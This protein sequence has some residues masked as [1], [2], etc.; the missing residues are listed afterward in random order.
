MKRKFNPDRLTP[1]ELELM[2]ILWE[3]GPSTVQMVMEG[4]PE[5][6]ELAYTTVQTMLNTLHRKKK[7]KRA[8]K[9]RAYY[10]EPTVSHARA[11]GHAL[12][13]IVRNLFGGSPERLV[14]AM[15]DTKQLTRKKLRELERIVDDS[16]SK[17]EEP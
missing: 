4:L 15:L 2:N 8:L 9:N 10:Y 16:A 5:G 1:A 12:N 13:D 11:A 14:L 17:K 7:L 3:R 6:R